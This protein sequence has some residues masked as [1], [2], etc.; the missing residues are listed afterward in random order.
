M[1]CL[2]TMATSNDLFGCGTLGLA[3]STCGT[4]TQTS[5]NLCASLGAPWVCLDQFG[6]ALDVTKGSS[7][8]GGVLCCAD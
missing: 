7:D 8:G 2:Q 6:E 4:L 3:D 1:G 5:A